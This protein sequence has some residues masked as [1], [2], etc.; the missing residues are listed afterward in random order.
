MED[1]IKIELTYKETE[2][3]KKF[4]QYENE[5]NVLLESG[6]FTSKNSQWI[7]NKTPDGLINNLKKMEIP[8]QRKRM[9]KDFKPLTSP[10]A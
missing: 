10:L 8:Y 5:F 1:K 7:A 2:S 4:R 9:K 3:F 6:F